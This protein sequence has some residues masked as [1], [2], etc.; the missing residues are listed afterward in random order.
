MDAGPIAAMPARASGAAAIRRGAVLMAA[1]LLLVLATNALARD[2]A[3]RYPVGEVLFFRFL[4][5][6]PV[7]VLLALPV[8]GAALS[9]RRIGVHAARAALGVAGMI[10]LYASSQHLPFS[11][12]I[13]I[14][15]SAP[16]FVALLAWPLLGERVS[17]RRFLL[18]LAGFAGVM[19]IA[20]PGEFALWS[21]GALAMAVLNALSVISARSLGRTENAAAIA[22]NFAALGA[23]LSAPLLIFDWRTPD[24]PDLAPLI[25]LGLCAGLAIILN[26][27]AFRHAP[28]SVLAPIDYAGIVISV[29]IGFLVWSELPT[30]FMLVGGAVLVGAGILQLRV[31]QD[32]ANGPLAPS[33]DCRQY[34]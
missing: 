7:V 32:E 16:I 12:L 4:G 8:G 23:L 21:L 15:Y 24:G 6:L 33:P 13:A 34:P 28:A 11:D 22:C 9:L 29:A 20:C 14:S 25:G 2:L 31:A 10:A 17:L 18:I 26:A 3:S 5:A 1:S 27:Q 30:R 19:L